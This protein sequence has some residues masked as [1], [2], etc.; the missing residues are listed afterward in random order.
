METGIKR[1]DPTIERDLG[2]LFS[3]GIL[4]LKSNFLPRM[5]S[6]GTNKKTD[7]LMQVMKNMAETKSTFSFLVD[8]LQH[9]IGVLTPRDV[10]IQFAPPCIDSTIH[11]VG[12]FE[13]ALEQTGCCVKDGTL[14]CNQ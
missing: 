1:L 5:D 14:V 10:I 3:A 9:V 13:S 8:D 2:A 11:G 4:R 12:F 6:P 7:T